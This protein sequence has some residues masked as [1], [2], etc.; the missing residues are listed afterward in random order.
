MNARHR[1]KFVSQ[2]TRL[3]LLLS[4][5]LILLQSTAFAEWYK[6]YES[7]VDAI[8]KN[9]FDA[10][11]PK[12]QSAIH[13]KSQEGANIKFYGMKFADYFPHYY[14][15]LCFFRAKNFSSALNE[16]EKSEQD[17]A[18]QKRSDLFASMN[19]MKTLSRAQGISSSPGGISNPTPT[20]PITEPPIV[21]PPVI[22][23]K[24]EPK[25]EPKQETKELKQE[26]K[27]EPEPVPLKNDTHTKEVKPPVPAPSINV[28]EEAG[29]MMAKKGAAK[30]FDGDY[31][32][33]ISLLSGSVEEMPNSPSAYFLL[34]CS[35]ASKYLLSGSKS[36]ED[37]KNAV[38][39]FQKTKRLDPRYG[40]KAGAYISPAILEIYT[41]S[42]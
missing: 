36:Q 20:N 9:Q 10:A 13:Q 35:Y 5:S 21:I 26:T 22:E 17:G 7:G 28:G 2:L 12:L 6:D 37:Y 32:G 42:S 38:Q 15:G 25:Q 24:Q 3:S 31:D 27:K 16:F 39:A 33:A 1:S 29:R 41:K 8:K 30:Y 18:I 14:L 23:Q 11:I 4:V 19:N 34:G 40:H